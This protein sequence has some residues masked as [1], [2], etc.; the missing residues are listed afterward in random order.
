MNWNDRRA[1]ANRKSIRSNRFQSRDLM[2]PFFFV[3]EESSVLF[4]CLCRC[5]Y[6][7]AGLVCLRVRVRV[8][9]IEKN[10]ARA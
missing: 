2:A 6:V 8:R 4:S 10:T 5:V 7:Y 3:L 9:L 1:R